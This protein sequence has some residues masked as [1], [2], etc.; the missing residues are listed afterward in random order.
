MSLTGAYASFL[1]T[2]ADPELLAGEL[3]AHGYALEGHLLERWAAGQAQTTVDVDGLVWSGRRAFTGDTLPAGAAAGD[4]WLDTRELSAMLLVGRE[5]VAELSPRRLA[6]LTPFAGWLSLRPVAAWQ[7]AGMLEVA[8]I[9]E[10]AVHVEPPLRTLDPARWRGDAE[11][12]PV[13]ALLGDEAVFYATWFGKGLATY[14]L[15]RA[16][17]RAS[18]PEERAALW[19]PLEREWADGVAEGV[20]TVISRDTV[21]ADPQQAY[22]EDPG[23]DAFFGD[24]AAPEGVG[25]RT[26]VSA[27]GLST[28]VADSLSVLDV[29][30]LEGVPRG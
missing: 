5:N 30:L 25:F 12:T 8:P 11:D 27:R 17:T 4:L 26:A 10:R 9:A 6:R 13:R 3:Q 19:G 28:V 22:E 1:R 18:T 14:A 23:G 21:D 24:F 16:A 29:Q 15:W 20:R 7:F 2:G